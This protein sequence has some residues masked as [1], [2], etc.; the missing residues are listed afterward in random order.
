MTTPTASV[1]PPTCGASWVASPVASTVSPPSRAASTA[2]SSAS[3]SSVVTSPGS[4]LYVT[5]ILLFLQTW[6]METLLYMY[7]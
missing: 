3:C 7:W 5:V 2:A 6:L 1:G 4:A